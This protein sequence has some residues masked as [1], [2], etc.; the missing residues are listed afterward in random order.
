MTISVKFDGSKRRDDGLALITVEGPQLK[1]VEVDLPFRNLYR[2]LGSPNPT[3]L[4]LLVV[5]GACYV[6]DKAV[7]RTSASDWWTRDLRV[8][9]P[10]SDPK[11]WEKVADRLNTALSFLSGD[12]WRT[13]F[14]Q[15]P[16]ELFVAPKTAPQESV[17][18]RRAGHIRSCVA[19]F[20]WI[21]LTYRNDR[22]SCGESRESSADDRTL[23]CLWAAQPT[24]RRL[25]PN[26]FTLS[27]THKT[28]AGACCAKTQEKLRVHFTFPL[29]SVSGV[30]HIRSFGSRCS[31]SAAGT[32]KW[33]DR[34]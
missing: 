25:R 3:A 30:G 13:S 16:C 11:R 20:W 31:R 2:S 17:A 29:H 1:R 33:N 27:G 4:D 22:L 28:S 24:K 18:A 14:R 7:K 5:A 21:G 6:V 19:V 34:S 15:S 23:R 8:S 26:A 9:F 32:G 10:V 12:V